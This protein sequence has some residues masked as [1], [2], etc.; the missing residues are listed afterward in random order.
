MDKKTSY[1]KT[2]VVLAA[3]L[4]GFARPAYAHMFEKYAVDEFPAECEPFY[5]CKG[6]FQY[7]PLT[8]NTDTEKV[9]LCGGLC[10]STD[11]IEE[12]IELKKL[13]IGDVVVITNAGSYAAVIT[14]MEFAS[15]RKPAQL[16]LKADG[17]V[18][19]A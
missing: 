3:T 1:G 12:D 18:T 13:D 16:M 17:T 10:T 7:V 4:T 19:E 9:T 11:I 2:F 5:T 8:E 14:P 6:A 15:L